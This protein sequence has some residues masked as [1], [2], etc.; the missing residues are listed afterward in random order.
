MKGYTGYISS[1]YG[2]TVE[3]FT[4]VSDNEVKVIN[5]ATGVYTFTG[6]KGNDKVS[7]KFVVK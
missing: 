4:V 3:T 1:V 5:L 7:I 6:V 2:N